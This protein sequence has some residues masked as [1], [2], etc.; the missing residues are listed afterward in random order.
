MHFFYLEVTND[1]L[2]K[3]NNPLLG[4]K[5]QPVQL[6]KIHQYT[7]IFTK[8][9]LC[10]TKFRSLLKDEIR[11]NKRICKRKKSKIAPDT[12]EKRNY[13]KINEKERSK[14]TSNQANIS[15]KA[16]FNFLEIY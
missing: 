12:P 5:Q 7:Q 10:S 13:E 4:L 9:F 1:V 2:K 15:K 16:N 11:C 8:H 14:Q 3:I 6:P